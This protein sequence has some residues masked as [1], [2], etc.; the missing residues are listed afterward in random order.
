MQRVQCP[1]V[2][3]QDQLLTPQNVNPFYLDKPEVLEQIARNRRQHR[4][5]GIACEHAFLNFPVQSRGDLGQCDIRS[6]ECRGRIAEQLVY[7]LRARLN[8]VPFYQCA[9][10]DVIGRH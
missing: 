9:G 2:M 6:E 10:I 3:A 1:Q 8:M 4:V 5:Q 7:P